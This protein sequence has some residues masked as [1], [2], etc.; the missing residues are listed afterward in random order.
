MKPTPKNDLY[1]I[2]ITN[3][4]GVLQSYALFAAAPSITPETKP[5]HNDI[6][7]VFKNVSGNGGQVFFTMPIAQLH[8]ICGT[9]QR[10]GLQ[11]GV[12][13]E[14]IDKER[15]Q[16][17][18]VTD[19]SK[20]VPGSTCSVEVQKGS[21]IFSRRTAGNGVG[22]PEAF[23]VCTGTDFAYTE[24]RSGR[25]VLGYG[26]STSTQMAKDI[27]PFAL[28]CP[29]PNTVYQIKPS[30]VFYIAKGVFAPRDETPEELETS[31]CKIDFGELQSNDAGLLHD[32]FGKLHLVVVK[33]KL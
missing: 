28:F 23:C 19:D 9:I 17:G 27:G 6:I 11:N 13:T 29:T 30:S 26:V 12:Q 16:L 24:A 33:P 10:D 14:I 8:A 18:R 21:L 15:V 22:E 31:S 7:T 1:T 5:I 32:E 25:F 4:S 3:N 20:M 2:T